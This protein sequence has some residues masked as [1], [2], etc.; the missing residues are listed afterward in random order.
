MFV[1][2]DNFCNLPLRKFILL[3]LTRQDASKIFGFMVEKRRR[4]P[5]GDRQMA[6]KSKHLH[7]QMLDRW[8]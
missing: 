6:R 3:Q 2:P 4:K 1:K 5:D 8:K 7:C